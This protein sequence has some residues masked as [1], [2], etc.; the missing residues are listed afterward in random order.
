MTEN[1]F[2]TIIVSRIK[3]KFKCFLINKEKKRRCTRQKKKEQCF[4]NVRGIVTQKS[5][6]DDRTM[7]EGES[8]SK[9][10]PAAEC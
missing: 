10:T 6:A 8:L 1:E 2:V 4:K 7:P 9:V 5:G 3:I